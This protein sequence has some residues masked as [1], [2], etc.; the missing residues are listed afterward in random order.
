[1]WCYRVEMKAGNADD[2]L[3]SGGNLHVGL[4]QQRSL[5]SCGTRR[6]W[7]FALASVGHQMVSE[8]TSKHVTAR[9]AMRELLSALSACPHT[10]TLTHT[11]LH[12]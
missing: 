12:W 2:W 9:E 3:E 11:P 10:H 6:E 1:M 4:E 8:T 5:C 7:L